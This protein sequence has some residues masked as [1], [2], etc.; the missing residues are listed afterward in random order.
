MNL[1]LEANDIPAAELVEAD[2]AFLTS[3]AGG[4]M[5]VS[6]V[7]NVALGGR[8]GPAETTTE[9]HNLYWT[10]RWDGWLDTP[11]DCRSQ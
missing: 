6:I 4:I 9:L 5:P 7:D 1:P 11:I 2:E 8:N 10:G 3:T